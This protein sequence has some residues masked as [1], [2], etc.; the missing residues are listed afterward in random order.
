[1]SGVQ[2][3]E[4]ARPVVVELAAGTYFWCACGQSSHQPFCDGSHR[5]LGDETNH[6]GPLRWILDQD[7]RVALCTCKRTGTPPLCDGSHAEVRES[8]ESA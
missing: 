5:A 1:M 6:D 7:R 3:T 2:P 4:K 8:G